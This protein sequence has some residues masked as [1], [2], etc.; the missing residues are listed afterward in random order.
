MSC[1]II[2][3]DEQTWR[4][5]EEDVRFFLL[6]GTKE[7]LLIDSGLK[8]RNAKEIAQ[9]LTELPVRLLNTHADPDHVGSNP[10]FETV[11]MN[12]AEC[13][14]YHKTHHKTG[15]I[16]PVWDGD[17][18]DLGDRPLEII[19]IPGHTPGSI[20]V[21][22]RKKRVLISGDPIQDGDIFMFGIQRE[23][24]A[25]RHSLKKLKKFE[26][27]FDTI[28]PSHGS[29]PVKPELIGLLDRAAEQVM[30]GEIPAEDIQFFRMPLKRY[31][32]EAAAFLLDADPDHRAAKKSCREQVNN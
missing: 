26:G 12:P 30:K 1:E 20:A 6:T 18:I 22:D 5:E 10:E 11:Y 17:V 14:N 7:A 3:I 2:R 21:L 16:T 31:D 28:Y 8:T 13:S 29:F 32:V 27:R 19:T 15:E 9:S 24:E 25:Y 4:M 23:M